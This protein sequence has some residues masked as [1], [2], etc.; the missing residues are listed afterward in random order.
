MGGI[1]CP[2]LDVTAASDEADREAI[3]RGIGHEACEL[4]A[5]TRAS[6]TFRGVCWRF[7]TQS[8]P[9]IVIEYARRRREDCGRPP[10]GS[11][12]VGLPD[13]DGTVIARAH[14]A[15]TVL[16]KRDSV[17]FF[18]EWAGI[19]CARASSIHRIVTVPSAPA[20]ATVT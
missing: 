10:N 16:T 12:S 13:S 3:G 2:A 15:F 17:H 8:L 20:R 7:G 5:M 1:V 19:E 4:E 18:F 9:P 14:E 11:A 6:V